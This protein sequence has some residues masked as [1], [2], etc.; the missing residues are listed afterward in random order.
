M[1]DTYL[2]HLQ[3][4][5]YINILVLFSHKFKCWY[6]HINTSCYCYIYY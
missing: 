4:E 1:F 2:L 5:L 3:Y 6:V